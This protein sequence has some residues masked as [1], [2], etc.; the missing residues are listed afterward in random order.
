ML[1][2]RTFIRSL[3]VSRNILAEE[4]AV[5]RGCYAIRDIIFSSRDAS[6]PL[7]KVFLRLRII[8]QNIWSEKDVVVSIKETEV[9]KVGKN[10]VIPIRKEFDTEEEAK[11]FIEE[12]YA[13]KFQYAFEFDRI[14]WQYDIGDDQVDLEDIEGHKSIE[15]KSESEEGLQR[16]LALF[17]TKDVIT[18][19]SVVEIKKILHL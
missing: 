1:E 12:K 17:S 5:F 8:P 11:A 10:S 6:L 16:L 7:E 3:E 2:A 4:K 19:S 14:G 18:G 15:F 9:K 13:K